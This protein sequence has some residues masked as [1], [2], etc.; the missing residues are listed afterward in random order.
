MAKAIVLPLPAPIK[1]DIQLTLTQDEAETLFAVCCR[2]GGLPTSTRRGNM[3]AIGKALKDVNIESDTGD[4]DEKEK[5]IYFTN[6][7]ISQIDS[8]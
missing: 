7:S 8:N 6:R 1:R 2:I 4:I 3:D 5:S